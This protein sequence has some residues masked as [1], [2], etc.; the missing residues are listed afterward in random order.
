MTPERSL[1]VDHRFIPY[2][3][4]IWLDAGD[5]MQTYKPLRQLMVAQD[6]GG[7]ITGPVRGDI[8]FGFGKMAAD[9]AGVMKQPGHY[10]LLLPKPAAVAEN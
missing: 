5:P 4:P 7:A 9:R 8:F 3:V 6:T 1:A 10:F 2:G